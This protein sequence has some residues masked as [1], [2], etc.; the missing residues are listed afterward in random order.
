MKKI[1]LI[2]LASFLF[3]ANLINV[4]FFDH[5]DKVDVLFSLDEKYKG[6]VVKLGENE[7]Y[8]SDI[9]STKIIK[10]DFKKDY[11]KKIEIEPYKD[12]IKIQIFPLKKIKTSFA[13]TPDGYGIRFRIQSMEVIEQKPLVK[14]TN[15]QEKIDY[16]SYVVGIGI[17]AFIGI[18]LF[19]LKRRMP[20]L[21]SKDL[22][23]NVIVQKPI[24]AKNRVVLFEFNKR[25][26]LMLVGNTNLL[27]DIF[28][29][30]MV[31]I[32]T[33]KEFDNFL[34]LEKLDE[35]KKY[36]K[37]AEELKELDERI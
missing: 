8:L 20:K 11:L 1:I 35:I 10:K 27:L 13:L 17:L 25:K 26:Y 19:F 18:I 3:A 23:M 14:V 7:Y 21:P 9:F 15:P 30:E 34:N 32:S 5:N 33:P 31:N 16:L 22:K 2:L 6:K 29:E 36:I 12:G 4:N 28:D 37:H 24:D